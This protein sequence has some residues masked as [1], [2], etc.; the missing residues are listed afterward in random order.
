MPGLKT[1]LPVVLMFVF[2]SLASGADP[3]ITDGMNVGQSMP[4]HVVQF[5]GGARQ[6]GKGCPSVMI[7]NAHSRGLEIWA[8]SPSEEVFQLASDLDSVLG[9]DQTH[10]GFMVMGDKQD[11]QAVRQLAQKTRIEEYQ[12]RRPQL[13]EA[14]SES[15]VRRSQRSVHLFDGPQGN[16]AEAQAEGIFANRE[17]KTVTRSRLA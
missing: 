15:G 17:N 13:E 7:S 12:R 8:S 16:Q 1:L 6:S 14:I 5:V 9:D 11:V 10:R 3:T 4:F 2:G